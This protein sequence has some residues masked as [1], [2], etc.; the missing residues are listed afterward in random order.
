MSAPCTIA[1]K[2]LA[3]NALLR[4]RLY[5]QGWGQRQ[6]FDCRCSERC[7][8]VLAQIFLLL[9]SVSLVVLAQAYHWRVSPSLCVDALAEIQRQESEA[10]KTQCLPA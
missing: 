2:F 6:T 1:P 5:L 10:R 4:H 7:C 9:V 3:I 8:F